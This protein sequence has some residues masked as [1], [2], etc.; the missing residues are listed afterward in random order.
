[1]SLCDGKLSDYIYCAWCVR[2]EILDYIASKRTVFVNVYVFYFLLKFC[3]FCTNKGICIF[4]NKWQRNDMYCIYKCTVYNLFVT[5]FVVYIINTVL[6]FLISLKK[7]H[8]SVIHVVQ[9]RYCNNNY[10][11][12][13]QR[14]ANIKNEY[15][16]SN[17]ALITGSSHLSYHISMHYRYDCTQYEW[18]LAISQIVIYKTVCLWMCISKSSDSICIVLLHPKNKVCIKPSYTQAFIFID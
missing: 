1:M 15:W 11:W 12:S 2:V 9:V 4:W 13:F 17:L 16:C 3:L 10:Y 7:R 14:W 8:L 18:L 5:N 6:F